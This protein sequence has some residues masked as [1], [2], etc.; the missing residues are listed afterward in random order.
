MFG[1][2]LKTN[3]KEELLLQMTTSPINYGEPIE[4][5]K[6]MTHDVNIE[7]ITKANYRF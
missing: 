4:H 2:A 6:I 5:Q 3:A 7:E 1:R